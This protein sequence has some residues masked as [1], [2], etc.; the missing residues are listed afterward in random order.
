MH[1]QITR[2]IGRIADVSR[3]QSMARRREQV[4]ANRRRPGQSAWR[5][6]PRLSALGPA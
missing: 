1:M 3:R 6:S 4:R 5:W 2:Q